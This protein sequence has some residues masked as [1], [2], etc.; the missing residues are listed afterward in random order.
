VTEATHTSILWCRGARLEGTPE[1]PEILPGTTRRL[2]LR[3]ADEI[4]VPFAESRLTLTDLIASD[5][6]L[7]AGTTTEVMPVVRVDDS[8]VGGG[9]PGPIA[10]RLQA[11]YRSAVERWLASE[12]VEPG[13][14]G[15]RPQVE[16]RQPAR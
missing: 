9:R 12:T 2:V 16:P 10:R 13:R 3:L 14:A 1:G 5:E 11:A 7:L 8:T 4:G 6:I 15:G